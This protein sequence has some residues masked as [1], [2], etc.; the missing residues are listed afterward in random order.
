MIFHCITVYNHHHPYIDSTT[1][2]SDMHAGIH[3]IYV[4]ECTVTVWNLAKLCIL[5]TGVTALHSAG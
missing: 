3:A 4:N 2:L 5:S 1:V